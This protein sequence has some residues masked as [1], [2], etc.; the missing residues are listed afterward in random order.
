MTYFIILDIFQN[1]CSF[2]WMIIIKNS[3]ILLVSITQFIG[4]E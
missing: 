1:I 3:L 4:I 2:V